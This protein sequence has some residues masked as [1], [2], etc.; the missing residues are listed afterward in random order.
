ML[1]YNQW[2][3]LIHFTDQKIII[4]EKNICSNEIPMKIPSTC[5][6]KKLR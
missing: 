4:R 5:N 2:Y 3:E 1:L 6:D